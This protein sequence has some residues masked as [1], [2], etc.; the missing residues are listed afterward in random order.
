MCRN[1]PVRLSPPSGS[2][3]DWR[4]WLEVTQIEAIVTNRLGVPTR[5]K[6]RRGEQVPGQKPAVFMD[7]MMLACVGILSASFE[8]NAC[9]GYL[10]TK[11]LSRQTPSTLPAGDLDGTGRG[12]I[13]DTRRRRSRARERKRCRKLPRPRRLLPLP[14]GVSFDAQRRQH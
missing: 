3:S 8:D 2:V 5:R 12:S 10:Q 14:P 13:S 6:P 9:A 11:L 7:V 1:A 4:P